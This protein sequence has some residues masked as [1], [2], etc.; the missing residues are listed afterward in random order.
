MFPR[1]VAWFLVGSL[2]SG[3]ELAALADS[4]QSGK[5]DRQPESEALPKG[6]V[7]RLGTTRFNASTTG[8]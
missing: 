6:A 2:L 8:D 7:A 1:M 3:A 4:G 5:P